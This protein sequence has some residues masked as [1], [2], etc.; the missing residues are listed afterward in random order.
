MR[1]ICQ[2]FLFLL[3]IEKRT[4]V[5]LGSAIAERMSSKLAPSTVTCTLFALLC[6]GMSANLKLQS[7]AKSVQVTLDGA[8]FELVHSAMANPSCAT[9][10]FSITSRNKN[11]KRFYSGNCYQMLFYQNSPK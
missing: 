6:P 11:F 10:L 5:Q 8:G 1:E 2:K 4:V 7:K 9:D 3:V